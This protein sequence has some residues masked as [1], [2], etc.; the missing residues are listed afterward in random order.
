MIINEFAISNKHYK[1]HELVESD[2]KK[3]RNNNYKFPL[4]LLRTQIIIKK[5]V[6]FTQSQ[7]HLFGVIFFLIFLRIIILT[8]QF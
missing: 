7:K 1:E 5:N 2:L 6:K 4:V 3:E 8:I